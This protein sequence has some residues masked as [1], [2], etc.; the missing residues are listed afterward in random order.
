M[1][2]VTTLLFAL[3]CGLLLLSLTGCG[4]GGGGAYYHGGYYRGYYGMGPSMIW[5]DRYVPIDP[6][7]IGRPDPGYPEVEL[8]IEPPEVELPIEPPDFGGGL[9]AVPFD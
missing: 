3:C 6:D 8:P 1:K 2:P 7:W 4:S 5:R 9:E